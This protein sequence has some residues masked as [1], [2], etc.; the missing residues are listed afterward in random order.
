MSLF[1]TDEDYEKFKRLLKITVPGK[2]SAIENLIEQMTETVIDGDKREEEVTSWVTRTR[3]SIAGCNKQIIAANATLQQY[4]DSVEQHRR[5]LQANMRQQE[6]VEL[7]RH[8]N[9]RRLE[10]EEYE[11]RLQRDREERT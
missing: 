5:R 9:E 1:V 10:Q 6:E 11:S 3:D 2:L 8:L 7:Q 4:L